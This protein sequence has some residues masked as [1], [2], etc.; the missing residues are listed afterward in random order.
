MPVSNRLSSKS[1]LTR[2]ETNGNGSSKTEGY[3]F[4]S[5]GPERYVHH[6]VASVVT[7]RRHDRH[8]RIALYC[9]E[10]HATALREKGIEGLF[11]VI[12]ELP[13]ENHS[14]VGFKHN[15]H[16]F[17]PFDRSLFVDADTVWCRDPDSLWKQLSAFDFTATGIER[18]DFFFGG[19]KGLGVAMDY[20]FDRRRKTMRRFGL[21]H[22]PRVQAGMIYAQDREVTERA[23][24]LA[25][26]Y[27]DGRDKTHFRSRLEEGRNEES[28]EWSLAMA[29]SGLELPIFPWLQGFNSPQLDYITGLTEHDVDFNEV[30]CRYYS[31][32]FVYN[33]RGVPN[34]GLRRILIGFFSRLPGRGDYFNVRP[35]VL[36]FGWLNHKQPF[37]DFSERNWRQIKGLRVPAVEELLLAANGNGTN[38]KH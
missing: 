17:M 8:R 3:V 32:R 19:P 6:V 26:E 18:S 38:G 7:L 1:H 2:V 35:Y 30:K 10:S 12:E 29:M 33:L 15:L 36:H 14:V 37:I 24:S 22:L 34:E 4:H 20:V 9:P 25:R 13:A 31:D 16:R 11:D 23:C 28:C 21:T 5:Y 27:F